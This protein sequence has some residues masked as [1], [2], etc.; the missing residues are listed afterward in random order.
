MQANAAVT[1]A[2]AGLGARDEIHLRRA[3]E[4]SR[5]AASRGNRPFGSVVVSAAGAV[6]GEAANRNAE[7]GD[8][9]GHAEVGAL[10]IASLA[11]P[12]AAFAGSTVYASGEPCVMCAGAIFWSGARRVVFGVDAATLRGFRQR[13]AG[14]GDLALS[15]RE[16]FAASPE[17]FEVLGPALADEALAPHLAYW[18]PALPPSSL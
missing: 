5:E 13:Q 18:G 15:C 14:A 4:L 11:H 6:L 2:G 3:I 16:V 7:T 10:R 12:R 9:T 1:P 17:P 8:C